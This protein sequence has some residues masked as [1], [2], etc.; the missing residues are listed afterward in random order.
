MMFCFQPEGEDD[1]KKRQLMELAIINGTYRDTKNPSAIGSPNMPM[2]PSSRKLG[3]WSCCCHPCMATYTPY[4]AAGYPY[5]P[6][7]LP[8]LPDLLAVYY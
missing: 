4:I 6:T 2:P 3:M 8:T 1:L 5:L 7:Y